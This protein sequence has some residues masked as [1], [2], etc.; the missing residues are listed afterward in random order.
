MASPG[1]D[2]REAQ[3]YRKLFVAHKVTRNNALNNVCVVMNYCSCCRRIQIC[4][5]RQPHKVAVRLS[6][7]LKL[8]EKNKF[9]EV[10][11]TRALVP[12]SWRRQWLISKS[13]ASPSGR[14]EWSRSCGI[15]EMNNNNSELI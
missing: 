5:E 6:A 7:A 15:S 11:G 3:N 13:G 10:E 14:E 4:L 8:T 2:A 1:C 12:H 9:L